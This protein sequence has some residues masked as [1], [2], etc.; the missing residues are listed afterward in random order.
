VDTILSCFD[1]DIS[2]Q[3]GK[4]STHSLAVLMTQPDIHKQ[5][6]QEIIPRLKKTD[7]KEQID[8]DLD[9]LR[10]NGPKKPEMPPQF[11]KK[12][13]PSLRL[14]AHM[15]VS[16]KRA[17]E[18]DFA[19]FTDVLK[20]DFCLEFNGYNTCLCHEQEHS[21]PSKTKAVYLPLI[22]MPPTDPDTFITAMNKAQKLT[23]ET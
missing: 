14:L 10:Y 23:E 19:F 12:Q 16:Q 4:L 21:F 20:L 13:V 22:D 15:V 11:I 17:K 3:N 8:Y 9:I 18:T 7:M 1:A 5:Q 2:S 6:G